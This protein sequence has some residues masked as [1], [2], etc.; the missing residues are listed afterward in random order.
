MVVGHSAK[1]GPDQTLL[2]HPAIEMNIANVDL[3]VQLTRR[4][5]YVNV[6]YMNNMSHQNVLQD[7]TCWMHICI[8]IGQELD[9]GKDQLE[10]VG[11][12]REYRGISVENA[13]GH[14]ECT[15][16]FD[17]QYLAV[18]NVGYKGDGRLDGD[19]LQIPKIFLDPDGG[20]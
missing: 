18:S 20:A 16:I 17:G 5:F 13:C 10:P 12:G 2:H 14:R 8:F 15:T 6:W 11:L 19:L 1:R 7:I 9:A 4:R 3:G